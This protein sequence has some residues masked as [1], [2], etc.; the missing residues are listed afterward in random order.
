MNRAEE[1]GIGL[2]DLDDLQTELESMLVDVRK[3]SFAIQSEIEAL[4]NWQ[5]SQIKPKKGSSPS[6]NA[7]AAAEQ[8]NTSTPGKR[9]QSGRG[10]D[11]VQVVEERPSKRSRV[12]EPGVAKD[13][14]SCSSSSSSASVA[15]SPSSR[16]S[17][18][19]PP[20]SSS[21]SQAAK[22]SKVK[23]KSKNLTVST[24]YWFV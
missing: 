7:A 18:T 6:K 2:E 15:S 16:S 3:R 11:E 20:V 19:P 21:K 22:D 24:F 14:S 17:T 12:S 1:E 9:K 23:S 5:E 13:S 4:T 8:Q 10:R